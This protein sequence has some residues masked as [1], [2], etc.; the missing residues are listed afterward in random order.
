MEGIDGCPVEF[1]E[2]PYYPDPVGEDWDGDQIAEW[3]RENGYDWGESLE[4][5]AYLDPDDYRANPVDEKWNATQCLV[6]I[7]EEG[8]YD[9]GEAL[10]DIGDIDTTATVDNI[11]ENDLILV[12]QWCK[13]EI[14]LPV[15]W[16]EPEEVDEIDLA[17]LRQGIQDTGDLE[18]REIFE[19]WLVSG[20]LAGKLEDAGEI[21]LHGQYWGRQCTGQA[22]KMDGYMLDIAKGTLNI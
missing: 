19:W 3:L 11:T 5:W 12:R 20:W 22:I 1:D 13:D 18:P 14:V 17:D 16:P 21:V 4:S 10:E 7:D 8:S 2:I 6:A 9:W 15:A